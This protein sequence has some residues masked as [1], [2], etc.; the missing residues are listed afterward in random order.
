MFLCS[1]GAPYLEVFL[2]GLAKDGSQLKSSPGDE[3]GQGE[4]AH[5][6]VTKT[7]FS[8]RLELREGDVQVPVA[9]LWQSS[10]LHRGHQT[11]RE[12][13]PPG[14]GPELSASCLRCL[15]GVPLPC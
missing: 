3:R 2:L 13:P 10:A 11:A 12:S 9:Q 14:V 15:L 8:P 7:S 5:T 6:L 4:D 1:L